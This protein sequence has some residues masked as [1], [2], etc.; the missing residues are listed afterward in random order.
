MSWTSTNSAILFTAARIPRCKFIYVYFD[1]WSRGSVMAAF[2]SQAANLDE[3]T[4][5][6]HRG[7]GCCRNLLLSD[8]KQ[9]GPGMTLAEASWYRHLADVPLQFS[10]LPPSGGNVGLNLYSVTNFVRP[11]QVVFNC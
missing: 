7:R 1:S 9:Q 8:S 5:P 2:M 4:Y 3:A 10:L 11:K 6:N